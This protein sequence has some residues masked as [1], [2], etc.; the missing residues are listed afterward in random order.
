MDPEDPRHGMTLP[1]YAF[2]VDGHPLVV[3]V[4]G[5]RLVRAEVGLGP[6]MTYVGIARPRNHR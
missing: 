4:G 2:S 1:I 3:E 5:T 6:G